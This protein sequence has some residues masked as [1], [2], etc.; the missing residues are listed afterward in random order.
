MNS[1]DKNISAA[2]TS[3]EA[4]FSE[5]SFYNRQTR[6][7]SH[8]EAILGILPLQNGMRILDLGTGSGY[9]SFAIAKKHP[10]I[11]I[12]GLDIVEKALKQNRQMAAQEGLNNVSFVNYDGST[13][14]FESN[15]FD[16]V[17]TRYSLHHFPDINSSLSEVDRILSG[18]GCF[19]ISDPAPNEGDENGF[20][21]EFMRVKPDGHIRFRTFSEL[22]QLCGKYGFGLAGSFRSSIRF[23]R[24]YEKAYGTIMSRYS[25]EIV[26][27]YGIEIKDDEIFITE[28]VNNMLFRRK[29]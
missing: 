29:Q 14:P 17:V 7:S 3:F 23:P 8:I 12:I 15:S 10:D 19:F 21:D 13:F 25:G 27:S 26:S 4:A 5:Q 18:K 2:K 22:V 9:L 1:S 20:A 6:D 24:K 16:M 28:R 11:T